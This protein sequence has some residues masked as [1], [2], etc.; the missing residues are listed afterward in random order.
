MILG[1][2]NR[3]KNEPVENIRPRQIVFNR[4]LPPRLTCKRPLCFKVLKNNQGKCLF[5]LF[6][7][8]NLFDKSG[9]PITIVIVY[10]SISPEYRNNDFLNINTFLKKIEYPGR[11]ECL[12]RYGLL[13]F[14]PYLKYSNT[15]FVVI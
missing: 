5:V 3:D 13:R 4:N 12:E 1:A 14:F 6:P 7:I 11:N 8:C 9:Y 10:I 2:A 15:K